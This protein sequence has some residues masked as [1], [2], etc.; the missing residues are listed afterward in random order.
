MAKERTKLELATYKRLSRILGKDHLD[1]YQVDLIKILISDDMWPMM[2]AL[3]A[4]RMSNG[5]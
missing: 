5:N 4:E 1:G 2:V 3:R